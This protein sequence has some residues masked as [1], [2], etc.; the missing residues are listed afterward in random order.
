MIINGL[1][2]TLVLVL[3]SDGFIRRAEQARVVSRARNLDALLVRRNTDW[4]RKRAPEEVGGRRAASC[5]RYLEA[6]M[7]FFVQYHRCYVCRDEVGIIIA[8]GGGRVRARFTILIGS[9]QKSIS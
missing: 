4:S 3:E 7:V 1:S 9:K 2:F 8:E 5:A 6:L